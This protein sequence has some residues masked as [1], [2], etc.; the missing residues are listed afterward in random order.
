M[1]QKFQVEATLK[2]VDLKIILSIL[3]SLIS[4]VESVMAGK[5]A[6]GDIDLEKVVSDGKKRKK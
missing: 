3:K 2:K 4:V 6:E 5:V 1:G